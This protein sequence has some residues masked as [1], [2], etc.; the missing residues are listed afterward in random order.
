MEEG[1]LGGR[2]PWWKGPLVEGSLGQERSADM[3]LGCVSIPLLVRAATRVV[4]WGAEP[5]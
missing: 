3:G 2:V 4:R 5:V 1:S